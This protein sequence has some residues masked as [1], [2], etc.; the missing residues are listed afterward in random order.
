[1]CLTAVCLS[2]LLGIPFYKVFLCQ[3]IFMIIT[4]VSQ[5]SK[6]QDMAASV[7]DIAGWFD[8][9]VSDGMAYMIIMCDT[10]DYTD[11]PVYTSKEGYA[12]KFSECSREGRVMEVYDLSMDKAQQLRAERVHNGPK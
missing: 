5:L 8:R 3:M 2:N 6:E 7:S 1:M 12:K 4:I 11:Y 9:G 10:W